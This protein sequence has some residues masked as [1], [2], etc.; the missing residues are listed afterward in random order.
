MDP[1]TIAKEAIEAD[2]AS[3]PFRV[4]V[5]TKRWKTVSFEYPKLV[6]EIAGTTPGGVPCPYFFRFLLDGFP[7]LA[8]DVRCWDFAADTVLPA[9][10]RP[11]GTARTSEAFKEWGHGVYRPWERNGRLH[12]NWENSHPHLA[13]NP[14]RNITFIIEELYG[15]CNAYPARPSAQ[16]SPASSL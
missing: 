2:L 15:L 1:L 13:W 10:R 5:A 8:P 6:I 11:K 7:T 3:A 12:N 4:G 9:E 14:A 16:T